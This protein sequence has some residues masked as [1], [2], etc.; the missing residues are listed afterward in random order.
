MKNNW[1]ERIES[2]VDNV[3][4][5]FNV[6]FYGC[7]EKELVE[8]EGKYGS[9]PNGLRLLYKLCGRDSWI[10][11]QGIDFGV[12]KIGYN[13]QLAKESLSESKVGL[14]LPIG[15]IVFENSQGYEFGFAVSGKDGCDD[16][17]YHFTEGDLTFR[18]DDIGIAEYAEMNLNVENLKNVLKCMTFR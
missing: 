14:E 3:K 17:I 4:K 9:I 8:I 10:A 16:E 7:T 1:K 11:F 18:K 6:K 13:L 5:E 2:A 12:N 15:S